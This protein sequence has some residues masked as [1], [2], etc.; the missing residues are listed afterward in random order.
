MQTGASRRLVFGFTGWSEPTAPTGCGRYLIMP[1]DLSLSADDKLVVS[2][3]PETK[4]LRVPGSLRTATVEAQVKVE[5]EQG[6]ERGQAQASIATGSQVEISLT[7]NG[8]PSPADKGACALSRP[9]CLSLFCF[10]VF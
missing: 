1:R 7:C 10:Q 8:T 3:I 4:V 5:Q 9:L 6:G 2:H